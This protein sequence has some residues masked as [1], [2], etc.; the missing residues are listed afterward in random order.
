[1][2][3]KKDKIQPPKNMNKKMSKAEDEK[4]TK[5]STIE[6]NPFSIHSCFNKAWILQLSQQEQINHFICFICKQ[7]A[8]NPI[9]ITCAQH[10]DLDDT[11]V[12]G[13]KCLKQ[14]LN[15]NPNSCPVQPHDDCSYSHSRLAQRHIG[16]LRVKCPRQFQQD[17]QTSTQGQQQEGEGNEKVA[18][19]FKGKIKELNNH[20]ENVCSL[21]LLDCWYKPFG[22]IHTCSKQKL[23]DHCIAEVK[24]HFDLVVNFVDSLQQSIQTYQIEVKQL[25]SENEQ[26]RLTVQLYEKEKEKNVILANENDALKKTIMQQMDKDQ[27]DRDIETKGKLLKLRVDIEIMKKDFAEKENKQLSHYDKLIKLLEEKNEK[28]IQQKEITSSN[29]ER[30]ENENLMDFTCI[31][32]S[33]YPFKLLKIFGEH[34]STVY[35]LQYLSFDGNQYLCSGSVDKTVRVW[36]LNISKQIQIF[37]GHSDSVRSAKF[38]PY[39]RNYS[40]MICSASGDKTIRFWYIKT[41][42]EY[43]TFNGHT[44]SVN[45][46]QF[47]PFTDGRYLCSGSS[48]CVLC[49]EFSPQSSNNDT[50]NTSVLGGAGYTI[51]SGSYDNTVRL[52]DVEN[53]KQLT[54]FK[55][56]GNAVRSVK[57]SQTQ[58]SVVGGNVICSGSD[59]GTVRLWDIRTGKYIYVFTHKSSVH[60]IAYVPFKSSGGIIC[61]GSDDGTICFWDIRANKQL[62]E[63]KE[64]DGCGIWSLEFLP[65]NSKTNN[66]KHK[67]NTSNNY[68]LCYGSND[69]LIRL[70]G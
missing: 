40:P 41:A 70:Y 26:L 31:S 42:K 52:W 54:V 32:G 35:S 6:E 3:V 24:S 17:A 8:N 51:C 53:T 60:A 18:C 9:E 43:Q 21:K 64:I 67:I 5:E 44:H 57:Y 30:K 61:S 65:F 13:E 50:K 49:V 59:D 56:H 55:G 19:D 37:T 38:S 16:D 29:E 68:T 36:D 10:E 69:G 20:L 47:S 4:T 2:Q 66:D 12:V 27:R 62:Y 46:I 15:T 33:V 25:Q 63:I 23:Q 1:M 58:L 14:F 7:V 45:C 28:C 48:D 39:H 22:C 34:L 11:L